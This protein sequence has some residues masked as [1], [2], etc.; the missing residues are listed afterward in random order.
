MRSYLIILMLSISLVVLAQEKPAFTNTILLKKEYRFTYEIDYT[1]DVEDSGLFQSYY[2]NS[3]RF[4]MPTENFQSCPMDALRATDLTFLSRT[5][6]TSINLGRSK[7]NSV[8][9][10]DMNGV[11]RDHEFSISF[12][13]N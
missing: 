9:R 1:Q 3:P 10:F 6:N 2:N 13:D 5:Y 12:S 11:L 4:V 7:L 8:Y